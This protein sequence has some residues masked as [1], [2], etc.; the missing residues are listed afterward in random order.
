MVDHLLPA[1]AADEEDT[2]TTKPDLSPEVSCP[3]HDFGQ[4]DEPPAALTDMLRRT[5]PKCG[6]EAAVIFGKMIAG[7]GK[8]PTEHSKEQR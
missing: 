2:M 4:D 3:P 5:C 8:K 6:A 7:S 1:G